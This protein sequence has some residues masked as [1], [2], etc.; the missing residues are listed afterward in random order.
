M[1]GYN[2]HGTKNGTLTYSSDSARYA[3]CSNFNGTDSYIEAEPLPAETKTISVWLKT[4]WALPPS[5]IRIAIHDKNSGLAIGWT[6]STLITKAGT[7]NGSTCNSSGKYIANQWNHI[8]VVKTGDNTRNIYI[9][10]ELMTTAINNYWGADLN[11]LDIG[12]RHYN[13]GYTGYWDGQ[14]SDFRAYAT[15][16]SADDIKELYNTAASLANNGTLFAYDFVEV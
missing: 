7:S 4:S 11:K 3:V 9:N 6:T 12:I 10:G 16:L 14:L 15:A 8:V 13:G 2:N 1:S 5:G